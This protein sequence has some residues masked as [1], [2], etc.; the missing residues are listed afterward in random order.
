M[1]K[2]K[3]I[4]FLRIIG[5]MSIVMLHLFN[6]YGLHSIFPNIELYNKFQ[7]MT[8]NGQKAVDLFFILSGFL[9]AY[10]FNAT[11]TTF[12]F[13]KLK[14]IRFFP[15]LLFVILLCFIASL[16]K[17]GT[18]NI[19]EMII[20]LA[21]LNGTGLYNTWG[22]VFVFWYVSSL[23]FILTLFHYLL[24]NYQTK[25]VNLFIALGIFFSYTMILSYTHGHIYGKIE[26]INNVFNLGILRAFAG[27]G[28]GYF[29]ALW[30][31]TRYN[32]PL[33]SNHYRL[34]TWL[35]TICEF[36]CLYFMINNL[37]FHNIK[38]NNDII[39]IIIFALTLV[40]FITKQGYISRI[41]DV[42]FWS[43]ISKYSYSIFMTHWFV[44]YIFKNTLWKSC[45]IYIYP[46][47][48]IIISLCLVF[49]LGI[50]TYH[51]VENPSNKYLNNK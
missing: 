48:N 28:I 17:I 38:Y 40:L 2:I 43:K 27:V 30:Y 33:Q 10:R 51:Y 3:N 16:F 19:Y 41:L 50:F 4:E 21:G 1:E 35:Y 18:F 8:S 47:L 34:K 39:F 49:A 7:T 20:T 44:Y 36:C 37:M 9:F 24:K 12:D 11:R 42:S 45:N 31:K 22:T 5:C 13:V 25:N 32:S 23:L 26:N 29:I 15:V 46:E 14:I 6:D